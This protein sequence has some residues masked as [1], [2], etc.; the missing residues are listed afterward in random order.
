MTEK[1][2]YNWERT[3]T[4]KEWADLCVSKIEFWAQKQIEAQL[5]ILKIQDAVK[6]AGEALRLGKDVSF[7]ETNGVP[8]VEIINGHK[9]TI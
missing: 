7:N 8:G 5:N 4:Q 6:T 3:L 9:A 2:V 1:E